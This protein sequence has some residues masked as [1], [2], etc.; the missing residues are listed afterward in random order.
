MNEKIKSKFESHWPLECLF[1]VA[2]Y[3]TTFLFLGKH[4]FVFYGQALLKAFASE[5]TFQLNS[6]G[7]FMSS[8]FR[9]CRGMY[10]C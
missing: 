2:L 7:H 10:R 9:I 3:Q 5:T 4:I 1:L 8:S 6:R